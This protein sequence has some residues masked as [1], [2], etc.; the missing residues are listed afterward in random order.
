MLYYRKMLER[1]IE[2]LG[3]L[4]KRDARKW[5]VTLPDKGKVTYAGIQ[6]LTKRANLYEK[7]FV[8]PGTAALRTNISRHQSVAMKTLCRDRYLQILLESGT[9]TFW[10]MFVI[11]NPYGEAPLAALALFQTS[12]VCGV[13]VTVQGDGRD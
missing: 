13:R 6:W 4:F 10:H 8:R 1:G 7:D 2:K 12:E 11:R 3:S 9:Y 5:T